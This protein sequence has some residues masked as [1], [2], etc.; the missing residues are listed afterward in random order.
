M[1]G[2]AAVELRSD[3]HAFHVQSAGWR[4][5]AQGQAFPHGAGRN[6][7]SW[8]KHHELI[9]NFWA[10]MVFFTSAHVQWQRQVTWLGSKSGEGGNVSP[11]ANP[12]Q[13]EEVRMNWNQLIPV[14]IL[15]I[16]QVGWSCSHVIGWPGSSPMIS[17]M[18]VG[19]LERREVLC[20]WCILL[21]CQ[22][23]T[24][25]FRTLTQCTALTSS[26]FLAKMANWY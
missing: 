13:D 10:G 21:K 19:V 25:T 3:P 16:M 9:G 11:T 15:W 26:K 14:N 12:G 23:R 22:E 20:V 1:C 18:K 17:E 6:P 5:S 24:P 7:G 4:A 8:V 2:W